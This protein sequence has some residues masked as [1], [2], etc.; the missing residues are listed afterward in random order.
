MTVSAIL[1]AGG[2]GLRMES[3][4]PKQF[5]TLNGQLI[6]TLSFQALA[7]CSAISEVIVVCDPIYRCH[8]PDSSFACPGP[9]RQDSLANGFHVASKQSTLIL[10]HDTARPFLYADLLEALIKA[11]HAYGA[12]APALPVKATIKRAQNHQVVETLKRSELFEIQTPQ[13]L[14][15]DLLAEGLRRA[16][17]LN[18]T[19]TD[20]ISLAELVKHPAQLI[21]GEE[22]NIKITTPFDLRIAEAIST[23]TISTF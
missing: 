11:G 8:F 12:A 9:R 20:D 3:C 10:I 6:A 17:E 4:I 13:I 21:P 7:R 1:L 5:L 2:K 23:A 15:A 22:T 16:E 19:V 14:K 18:L